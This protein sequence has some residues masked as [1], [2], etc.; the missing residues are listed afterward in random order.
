[1]NL[2]LRKKDRDINNRIKLLRKIASNLVEKRIAELEKQGAS[3]DYKDIIEALVYCKMFQKDS[4]KGKNLNE[5]DYTELIEEFCT[6]YT[7]GTDTTA[8]LL[9]MMIYYIL[10]HPHVEKRLRE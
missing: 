5:Y 2:G 3:K 8:H 9:T 10:Q 6:F 7:A 1:M 4:S